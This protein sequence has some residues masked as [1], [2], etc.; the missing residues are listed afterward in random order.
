MLSWAD[1]RFAHHFADGPPP[2]KAPPK[3][4]RERMVHERRMWLRHLLAYGIAGL[5]LLLFSALIG[6]ADR[7]AQ[8]W[9]VFR[10]WSLVI[11]IDGV[12]A[13]S[14]TTRRPI[15]SANDR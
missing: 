1:R 9:N 4:T 6:D 11:V 13:L 12:V 5:I 3:S 2:A 15:S 10:L 14:Y 7:T 8:L